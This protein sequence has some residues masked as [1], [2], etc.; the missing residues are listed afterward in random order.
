MKIK[1]EFK[2][3]NATSIAANIVKENF[4]SFQ[5][6]NT[7]KSVRKYSTNLER[8]LIVKNKDIQ[9]KCGKLFKEMKRSTNHRRKNKISL[10]ANTVKETFLSF[11]LINILIFV[12]KLVKNLERLLIVRCRELQRKW[13]KFK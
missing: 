10:N 2:K 4:Q 1:I 12:R 6:I 5:L 3:K 7:P 11:Q 8:P 13:A 9:T